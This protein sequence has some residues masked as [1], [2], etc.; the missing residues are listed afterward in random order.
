MSTRTQAFMLEVDEGPLAQRFCLLRAPAG[1]ALHGLVVHV[2][3]FAEEMNKS[4]RAVAQQARALAEAGFAV[5]QLDLLGCGDSAGDFSDATWEAWR[6]DVATA[7]S[8]LRGWQR[9]RRPAAQ[10]APLWLWGLRAGCLLAAEALPLLGEPAGLLF[11]QPQLQG[12][13]VLQ[14][15]LRLQSAGAA[16]GRRIQGPLARDLLNA[17]QV[18]DVAGYGLNPLLTTGMEAATGR[19]P[20][21]ECRLV[22]LEVSSR[23]EPALAPAAARF[24]AEWQAQGWQVE[25][26]AVPGPPFWQTTEIEEAPALVAATLQALTS[27]VRRV[28]RETIA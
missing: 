12:N 21:G 22:W 28:E 14:Q 2:M 3:A 4:R 8:W 5:L 18:A 1:P 19:P 16:L 10:D 15:F 27:P 9:D 13:Q 6:R 7:C 23:P 11:W 26:S 20:A 24:V 17:G 25:A